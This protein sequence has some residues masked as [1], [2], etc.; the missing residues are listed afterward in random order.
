MN[1]KKYKCNKD[2]IIIVP[3]G[4]NSLHENWCD[5]DIYDLF[6]IY[7]DKNK[8]IEKKYKNNADFFHKDNGPKWQIIKRALKLIE[9]EKYDYVWFP[10]DN[11]KISKKNIEQ[12]F[13]ISKKNIFMVS[14]PAFNVKGITEC[15]YYTIKIIVCI[16]KIQ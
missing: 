6:V 3:V 11:L 15:Q 10:D 14:Q 13:I 4:D 16:N 5:S 7:Y 2:F 12:L 8:E 1:N 9:L